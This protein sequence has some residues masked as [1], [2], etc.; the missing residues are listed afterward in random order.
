[1]CLCRCFRVRRVLRGLL[2]L[3]ERMEKEYEL[4]ILIPSCFLHHQCYCSISKWI[5]TSWW[6]HFLYPRAMMVRSDPEVCPEN[7]WV[8]I[9]SSIPA[10][11]LILCYPQIHVTLFLRGPLHFTH[12][13]CEVKETFREKC[14]R[15]ENIQSMNH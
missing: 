15:D 4:L 13:G 11:S 3:Q 5:L 7:R 9:S 12:Y 10:C 2:G 8:H 14:S 6:H 1:M